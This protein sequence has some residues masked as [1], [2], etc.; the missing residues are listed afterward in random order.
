M[1][2][3]EESLGRIKEGIGL[4]A[5]RQAILQLQDVGLNRE[6]KN[7]VAVIVHKF[8]QGKW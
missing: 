3:A 1:A 7:E 6:N 5:T 8:R 4:K 2:R